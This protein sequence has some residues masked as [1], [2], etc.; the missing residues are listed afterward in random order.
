MFHHRVPHMH[1]K[2]FRMRL[3]TSG[4]SSCA[5]AAQRYY[6]VALLRGHIAVIYCLA[7]VYLPW[8]VLPRWAVSATV[9]HRVSQQ[10]QNVKYNRTTDNIL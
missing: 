6:M 1:L 8:A 9:L 4:C 7:L 5:A 3:E 10:G 2:S